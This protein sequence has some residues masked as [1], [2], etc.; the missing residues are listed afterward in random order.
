[1]SSPGTLP[2]DDRVVLREALVGTVWQTGCD[3]WYVDNEGNNPN[4]WPWLWA[5]YRKRTARESATSCSRNGTITS[6]EHGIFQ[7]TL[8]LGATS[9]WTI[10]AVAPGSGD[11]LGFALKAPLNESLRASPFPAGG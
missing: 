8:P 2:F 1:M 9:A 6:N 3:S 5:T 11:S 7:A 10:R 4:N